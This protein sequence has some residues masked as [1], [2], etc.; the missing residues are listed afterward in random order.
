MEIFVSAGE[1]SSD[2]HCAR[3]VRELKERLRSNSGVES[4]FFGLGGDH[5]AREG[6]ELLM[7]NREF[8]VM[9]GPLEVI[10]RLPKR[11]KLEKLLEE[12]LFR[13]KPGGAILVDNGEI[14]LRL[15]SLLH[16]FGVP[17]VYFIP[18]KVWVW[19][20]RRIEQIA[21]HVNL[22]LS[23]LPFE[24]PMYRDWEVPFRYVGNPLI[25]EVPLDLSADQARRELGLDGADPVITVFPGSRHSE[26]RHHVELFSESLKRF[27]QALQNA[28][29]GERCP[30]VLVPV[31]PALDADALKQAFASRLPAVSLHFLAEERRKISVSHLCLKA[32][33]AAIVK[34]GTS[35]LEAAVLGTPM[36]LTYKSS[37]TSQ[38][39]FKHVTGYRG[40]IGMANLFLVQPPEAALGWLKPCEKR[41]EPPVPELILEKGTPEIIAREFLKI[42]QDGPERASML[43]ALAR[44]RAMLS[45]PEGAGIS[46]I[47][48]A[49]AAA[50][51]VFTSK[52]GDSRKERL[53]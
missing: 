50:Y 18:P 13:R 48:C 44:A 31:A 3:L 7:H 26:I 17:V 9:G 35:T 41:P 11:R 52:S 12:R 16:F 28:S 53:A 6:A 39:L 27:F 15:A 4:R 43:S 14:N 33:R 21:R 30:Q 25:D 34:S 10:G 29:P 8:S 40:F 42:Y 20:H 32:A 45:P 36:V 49:A 38:W 24:E 46:P 47:R 5:L 51:G 22:V 1:A 19:R 23:I 37:R 2:I